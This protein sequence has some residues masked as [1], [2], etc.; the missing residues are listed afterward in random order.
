MVLT[1]SDVDATKEEAL[2]C[3]CTDTSGG[4]TVDGDCSESDGGIS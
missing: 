4:G 2:A 1:T 3:E